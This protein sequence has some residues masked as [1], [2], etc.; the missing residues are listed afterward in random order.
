MI[1]LDIEVNLTWILGNKNLLLERGLDWERS[2][3]GHTHLSIWVCIIFRVFERIPLGRGFL[4]GKFYIRTKSHPQIQG[5]RQNCVRRFP[6]E[7]F[8]GRSGIGVWWFMSR[9]Q[10]WSEGGDPE[11]TRWGESHQKEEGIG[12]GFGERLRFRDWEKAKGPRQE[13]RRGT[14]KFM[15]FCYKPTYCNKIFIVWNSSRN[16][17]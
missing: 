6:V 9:S 5:D 2:Q 14:L 15:E 10:I 17:L 3:D 16:I 7:D 11:R 4:G 13:A 12:I 8:T 1:V